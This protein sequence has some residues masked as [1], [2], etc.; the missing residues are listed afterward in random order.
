MVMNDRTVRRRTV[1]RRMVG[2]FLTDLAVS[3]GIVLTG[4]RLFEAS[5]GAASLR[6]AM[7]TQT[8]IYVAI[9]RF[10]P[11]NLFVTYLATIDDMS[12]GLVH[13]LSLADGFTLA[14]GEALATTGRLVLDIA[15]AGPCTL[16]ELYRQTSGAAEWVVLAGFGVTIC[17]MLGWLLL[18]GVSRWRLLLASATSPFAAS[19]VFLV[20]QGFMVL[21]PEAFFWF[22]SLAPYT[23]ACPVICTL[24]WIAFPNADR[25]ATQSAARA[26]GAVLDRWRR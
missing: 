9:S 6:E 21:L 1:N 3:I 13:G 16:A 12:R 18:T 20:L 23:V 17:A 10:T 19:A 25:G 5:A 4:G 24:Y 15:L 7:V 8:D 26:I 11:Q 22:T 2:S 14:A